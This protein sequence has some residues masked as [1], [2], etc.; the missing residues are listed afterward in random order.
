MNI[1][2]PVE[3]TA[4]LAEAGAVK[5]ANT[6][7]QPGRTLIQSILAGAYVAL[8]G[9]FS[10]IAG[11]GLGDLA[12]EMPSLQRILSGLTFPLGLILVVVLGAELFTGNNAVLIPSLL[13][14]H[15]GIGSL[16]KN[17]TLV[18]LG[19]FAGA[20]LITWLLVWSTGVFDPAQ[21]S[22]AIQRVATAKVSMPWLTVFAKGIG[23]NWCVCLAIWLAMSGHNLVEKMAGCFLPVMAF[24][25]IG[26]EHSIANMFFI[27]AGMFYGA[28]IGI[29]Q[30]FAANL[31]PATLGNIVGGALFVG[32]IYGWLHLKAVASPRS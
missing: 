5:C 28:E 4:K 24:V 30:M 6:D 12:T 25:V 31:I 23:A 11:W 14:R 9:T 29:W 3:I 26:Y 17:W 18:W 20:L 15:H 1:K 2:S 8:G 13:R 27:P 22:G 32:C 7:T 16:A 21:Y 19:N 10:V